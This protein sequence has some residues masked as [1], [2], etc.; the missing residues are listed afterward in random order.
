MR[1]HKKWC[2]HPP[3]RFVQRFDVAVQP[4]AFTSRSKS[5]ERPHPKRDDVEELVR[6]VDANV[7][8]AD[9]ASEL[10]AVTT[11]DRLGGSLEHVANR[12]ESNRWTEEEACADVEHTHDDLEERSRLGLVVHPLRGDA[13]LPANARVEPLSLTAVG[14]AQR[15]PQ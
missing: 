4:S 8:I 1:V 14:A 9:G 11:K 2:Y 15:G 6:E 12:T 13:G 10:D 7:E 5:K 3:L